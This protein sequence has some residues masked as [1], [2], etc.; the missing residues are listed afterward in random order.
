[1]ECLC[2]EGAT[3]HLSGCGVMVDSWLDVLPLDH[4]LSGPDSYHLGVA[5]SDRQTYRAVQRAVTSYRVE[6]FLCMWP[7]SKHVV[8]HVKLLQPWPS[9]PEWMQA[10]CA[11]SSSQT[12]FCAM[13]MSFSCAALAK[14]AACP[15]TRDRIE[16][17]APVASP[18][19]HQQLMA[20][21]CEPGA[22]PP[23]GVTFG[24]DGS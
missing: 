23:D 17:I 12:S 21:R 24:V 19:A 2:Q 10:L 14:M 16:A 9:P 15:T 1:M 3:H 8:P 6:H 22:G 7:P 18:L 20:L 4:P 11:C 13:S 5:P